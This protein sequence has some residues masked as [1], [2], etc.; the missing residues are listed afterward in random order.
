MAPNN[1]GTNTERSVRRFSSL[2]TLNNAQRFRYNSLAARFNV[3]SELWNKQMR[4]KEEGKLPGGG[5]TTLAPEPP[6]SKVQRRSTEDS[7][8]KDLFKNYSA[9]K[10]ASGE[11][12][13]VMNY[14]NFL[15]A[16]NKQKEQIKQQHNCKDVEFYL[17]D[18]HG[19]TKLKAKII[20]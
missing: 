20:K 7:K 10:S 8:L 9:A 16:L 19:R 14:E 13:V 1:K 12:N 15:Q 2:Q 6:A 3:Y 5:A 18:E 4:L 11:A 17:A